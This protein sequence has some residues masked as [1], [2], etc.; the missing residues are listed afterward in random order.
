MNKNY[1]VFFRNFKYSLMSLFKKKR[2]NIKKIEYKKIEEEIPVRHITS[3]E[4]LCTQTPLTLVQVGR[5]QPT[6]D[7]DLD[8]ESDCDGEMMW[9]DVD[10]GNY[11]LTE[12]EKKEY[13]EDCGIEYEDL[14]SSYKGKKPMTFREFDEYLLD[15]GMGEMVFRV[16]MIAGIFFTLAEAKRYIEKRPHEF[17]P[18]ESG[19]W[20]RTWTHSTQ[21]HLKNL[22]DKVTVELPDGEKREEI[23]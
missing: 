10:Y 11:E 14:D 1:K 20:W 6:Y 16:D 7:F 2:A 8:Y 21:G 9:V 4:K 23:D 17:E 18:S 3:N 5:V 22:L 19:V 12:E 15:T 13:L